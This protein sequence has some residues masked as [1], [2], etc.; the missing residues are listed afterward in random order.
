[1]I[2]QGSAHAEEVCIQH[3]ALANELMTNGKE[4]VEAQ[5]LRVWSCE[6]NTKGHDDSIELLGPTLEEGT[7]KPSMVNRHGIRLSRPLPSG[8]RCG[9][10]KMIIK[11]RQYLSFMNNAT[12]G[13]DGELEVTQPNRLL[14]AYTDDSIDISSSKNTQGNQL[15]QTIPNLNKNARSLSLSKYIGGEG[16]DHLSL[17]LDIDG[18]PAGASMRRRKEHLSPHLVPMVREWL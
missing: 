9:A 2:G 15:L 5:A 11:L 18:G 10:P 16:S 12:E 3:N 1:M 7:D 4:D 17:S 14:G 8:I 6:G 13:R